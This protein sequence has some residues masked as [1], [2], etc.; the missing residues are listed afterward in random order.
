[1]QKIIVLSLLFLS[2]FVSY[3]NAEEIKIKS[4]D[5]K[6]DLFSFDLND[7]LMIF[8]KNVFLKYLSF[9]VSC[10]KA[11]VSFNDVTKKVNFIKLI[12]KVKIKKNNSEIFGDKVILNIEKNKIEVEGN[13]KTKVKLDD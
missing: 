8:E 9:D 2:F 1:M 12:G 13:V 6:S 5:V 4:I 7:S 11:I 3:S 10:Q